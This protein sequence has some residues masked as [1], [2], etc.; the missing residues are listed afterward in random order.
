MTGLAAFLA[1]AGSGCALSPTPSLMLSATPIA[2]PSATGTVVPTATPTPTATATPTPR[3]T[4]TPTPVPP[5]RF[6]A[7]GSMHTARADATATLLKNGK[8]LIAGGE[9]GSAS[10]SVDYYATAELYDPATGTFTPTGSMHAARAGAAATL[11][12]NRKVLIA[13]GYG[14]PDPKGCA[15]EAR[16][17]SSG[18]ASAELYDPDT[19]KFNPTGSMSEV[20]LE[21]TATVLSD[22]RVLV[23]G[24]GSGAELYEPGSGKFVSAGNDTPIQAP[25]TATLLAPNGKVLLTGD[26]RNKLVAQLYDQRNHKFT[27]ISLALPAGSPTAQYQGLPV[28]R[29]GEPSTATLLKDGRVLLF[30][31]GYLE[32]YDPTSGKCAYAGFISP[33]RGWGVATATLLSDGRVLFEGGGIDSG[34][35]YVLGLNTKTA[36]LYD[37]SSGSIRRGS[38]IAARESQTATILADGSVLIAGGVDDSNSALASAELFKP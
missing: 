12:P 11:L 26:L 33:T 14:C 1:L 7:T 8:V 18:L 19:G 4:P 34:S 29:S 38:T 10:G 32:T 15:D 24:S 25:V 23:A 35:L 17:H 13:G 30:D 5:L 27:T 22:G 2:T 9:T 16:N 36:V 20:R 6:V 31:S 21:A 28:P 37:P 3:P